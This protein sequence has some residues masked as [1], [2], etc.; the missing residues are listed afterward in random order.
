MDAE[1]PV[2]EAALGK[3]MY[4][5]YYLPLDKQIDAGNKQRAPSSRTS[6]ATATS[7]TPT[8]ACRTA[9]AASIRAPAEFKD[10]MMPDPKADPHGLTVDADGHVWW[11]EDR[12]LLPRPAR[13]QDRLDGPL[14]MDSTGQQ[15]GRGHSRSWTAS[16]TCGSR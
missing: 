16:R 4:V 12:R 13:S 11:A 5:E 3:A 8:A 15:K 2:D 9:S 10:W 7:G 14:P 1:F 6:I